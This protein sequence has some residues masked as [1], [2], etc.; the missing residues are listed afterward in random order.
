M[1]SKGMSLECQHVSDF[2]L[3]VAIK[4]S[5]IVPKYSHKYRS[6]LYVHL[7]FWREKNYLMDCN[8]PEY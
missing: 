2:D 5:Y 7:N 3:H 4:L 6:L 8:F 1:G